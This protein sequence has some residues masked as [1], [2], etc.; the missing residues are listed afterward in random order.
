MDR[1]VGTVS[2]GV[3]APIIRQGD[4]LVK[5]VVDS[6][7]N[8]SKS[9]NFEVRD[10]D[11]IAVTEAVV[12]R[13]QGNYAHVDNIAKDV[14]DK[15]GDDTVGVIFPILSRNRFA[16]CL[17]GIA[18]GCRKVVLMLSYPSDEVGNHLI[19]IDELDDKGINPW[20][21]VLTE[22]KY[23]ELFGYN[24][25]TFTGVDYVDYYKNLIKD[26]GAE[27]EIVFAN[28]PKTILNY[29][30]SILTCDIHTR[31][32]TKRILRQ[33]GAKK[34]YSLDDIMTASVDGSGYNDQYGLLGSNKATEETVK[35]FPI[36]CDEV[37]NKIQGD[38]KEIT[39]KDVEVMVYGDGAFKDPVG[40]IWELADP[41]VSPAYTKGL[42]GT[43]NEVKLKYLA[44]ND[45][46]DLSG[47]ELKEAISK[48]IVEKDNK[49]DDLTGNMVSQG[50]TPRRLTDLIGSLADLTSGSGDKGTPIIYI[51]GY[52][53]NYTK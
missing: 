51:Q 35:L 16:I 7:L 14:K 47:D 27:V 36:N 20:S 50:T 17:K 28:N 1:L 12:A 22:E 8:A 6:V 30:T 52:F 11:V 53:D 4:D 37:V 34:V 40:K 39:G 48:Y 3:R 42:E 25:H 43:P 21:D 46:A 2:R 24:K 19:S 26:C 49:S 41:V 44:D 15:F 10:K 18:K 29:T 13:A 45:F 32:R 33:N 5:I 31:Q 38:I 23:R 9:E